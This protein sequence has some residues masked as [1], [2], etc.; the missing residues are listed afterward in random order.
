[1]K[2]KGNPIRTQKHDYTGNDSGFFPIDTKILVL[3]DYI[4]DT[5]EGGIVLTSDTVQQNDL[6]VTEGFLVDYGKEAFM[7]WHNTTPP[8]KG[9]RLVWAVYAGQMLEGEDGKM[10][11][12]INDTDIAAIKG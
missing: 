11:R 12:L 3:P 4:D 8:K 6:A 10:Y 5:S 7:D 2:T 9:T 1:M